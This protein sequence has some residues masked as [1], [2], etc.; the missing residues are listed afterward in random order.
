MGKRTKTDIL[1]VWMNGELA[2]SWAQL[3]RGFSEFRYY[4]SWLGSQSSRPISLSMPLAS[5]TISYTGE[6][7]E[8]YFDNLLPDNSEI[9]KRIQSRFATSSIAPF[10][11]LAQIGR[12]CVGAIQ[13]LPVGVLPEEIMTINAKP[14]DEIELASVLKSVTS[15]SFPGIKDNEH[16]RI[17]VAGAQEKT[18]FLQN[19]GKWFIPQG[20]TPTTH[21]FK[22]PLG[23]IM[24]AD[25]SSSIENEWLCGKIVKAFGI[26]SANSEIGRFGDQKV[27]I[28]ERFDRAFSNDGKWIMRFPVEDMC[29]TVGKSPWEKYETDGGPGILEI[30]KVLLGSQNSFKDR[31]TFMKTQILFWMLA[32]PDGHA[33]NFSIFIEK[34]GNYRLTPIYDVLSVYPVMGKKPGQIAPEKLRMAMAVSGKNRHY[35]WISIKQRHWIETAEK[36]GAGNFVEEILAELAELTPK[37]INEVSKIIPSDFPKIVSDKIFEGL[38]KAAKI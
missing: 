10:D 9:R 2:G 5:N 29:Q 4:D 28:V 3:S 38:E 14:L 20:S 22:L 19:N 30:M 8:N 26:E 21:I 6:I 34:K 33:K 37:V 13:L 31:R 12:D 23:N 16:F 7:V 35:D 15:S 32:A 25:M 36:C 18:A 1:N 27:L 11:L 24:G 17:S